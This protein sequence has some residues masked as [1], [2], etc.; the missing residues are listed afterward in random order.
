[1]AQTVM[2]VDPQLGKMLVLKQLT[3]VDGVRMD[4]VRKYARKQLIM[5]GAAEAETD[6]PAS[7]RTRGFRRAARVGREGLDRSVRGHHRYRAR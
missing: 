4:D 7:L 2:G 6:G 5:T 1:M 3:L